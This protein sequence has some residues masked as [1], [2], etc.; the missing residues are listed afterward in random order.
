MMARPVLVLAAMLALAGCLAQKPAEDPATAA[1]PD[2]PS[3]AANATAEP[4]NDDGTRA[5]TSVDTGHMPH[6]HD[7]WKGKE[8]VTIF[9]GDLQP[10]EENATFATFF[11]VLFLHRAAA[12]GMLWNPPDG[13]IVYEGTGAMELT[14]TWTDPRVTS[15]AFIYHFYH[16]P[17]SSGWR[18]G[19]SLP[20]GKAFSLPLTPDMTD[21]PHAKTSKWQLGFGPDQEPGALLGPFHLKVDLVRTGDI[22]LFPA[23]PDLWEGKH[24]RVVLDADHHG[25]QVS[26]MKRA[27]QPAT[28]GNFT[29]DEVGFAKTVPMETRGVRF[30]VTVSS[31]TSTPG[32]V[33]QL[34]LFVHGADTTNLLRCA[35]KPL[36]ATLPATVVWEIPATMDMSDSPYAT[37]SAWRFL[38]EPQTSFTGVDPVSGGTT[39]TEIQYHAVVTA[40]DAELDGAVAC[41]V[42]GQ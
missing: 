6:M 27:A 24:E 12:G 28:Q 13:Q 10:D 2:G 3:R 16:S 17:D 11:Q 34:G 20:N 39:D 38:V 37:Q 23:H 22:M 7:Y 29:E 30:A 19:G 40:Y 21:M 36:N 31:A 33:V 8:R 4:M 9:D 25:S 18:N 1:A 15:I 14:A 5:A 35:T 26:Y 42:N 32:K 41:R